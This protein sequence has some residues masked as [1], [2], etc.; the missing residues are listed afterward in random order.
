M[1]MIPVISIVG[2]SNSGKTSFM[3]QLIPRLIDKGLKIATIKHD[4]HG[5]TIDRP[6][7]DTWRHK[8]S[9]AGMVIISS[10]Q[11]IAMVFDVEE[12]YSLDRLRDELVT[13]YDLILTE[14]Y[15]KGDKPKIEVFRPGKYKRRLCSP[16]A[17]RILATVINRENCSGTVS[18]DADEMKQVVKCILDFLQRGEG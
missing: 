17:D 7:K 2:K 18:F 13:G 9:G 16:A 6:G 3:E 5:F 14:G 8:E 1:G 11:K 12:E 10:P 4:V 15:K